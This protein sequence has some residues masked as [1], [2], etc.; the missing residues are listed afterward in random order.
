MNYGIVS[1]WRADGDHRKT[2][3]REDETAEDAEAAF[4]GRR[5][6]AGILVFLVLFWPRAARAAGFAT[7]HFGGEQGT[8][9]TSN[10]TA[11]YYNP[12]GIGFSEG[13]H[14]LLDG[15]LALRNLD[16]NHPRAPSDPVDPPGGEGANIGQAHSLNI[17]GAPAL[18]ATMKLGRFAFGAGFFVPFGGQ[19]SWDTNSRFSKSFFLAGAG[20]QRWHI[21][22]GQQ[23]YIYGTLGAAYRI[24]PLSV[25]AAGNLVL[26]SVSLLRAIVPPFGDP[27]TA[28]EGRAQL[29]VSAT[30]GGF[31]AGAELEA[32]PGRLWLA[33]SYQSQP[34]VGAQ[35]L[36]G[37]LKT[38]T[39]YSIPPAS[40]TQDV[41]FTQALP[42]V[43]RAGLRWRALEDVEL[44][45]FGDFT[46]W[47]VM[48]TQCLALPNSPCT[49]LPDGSAAP[50][51]NVL[52]NL[53]RN[54]NDTYHAHV[55]ASYW[56]KPEI[57]LFAGAG[58]ETAATPDTT[59]ETV[60][61]DADTIEGAVGGR[62]LVA[63]FIYV[64]VS[65]TH[66][67]SLNRDTTGL[68]NLADALQP[69]H[70]Q[71]AGGRYSQWVGLVDLNLEKSF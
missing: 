9:L 5:L 4:L 66:L 70:Q 59:L 3:R 2:R 30:N 29:D 57:E 21:I 23:A 67:Q 31:A 49:V 34:G 16:F 54:W 43:V 44:R 33:A 26:S 46:R 56:V 7:A 64:A 40:K 17:F 63:H 53:R 24:G 14:V 15:N 62:F 47:S 58:F 10:P 39:P 22:N 18:G 8:V 28:N 71:D 35:T 13:I 27:D 1:A 37:T 52:L 38:S 60:F 20:P 55:G 51:A 12:A 61:M 65:Y 6:R 36:T 19:E 32:V 45:V 41:A 11:L 68:N 42:D 69:T 48:R 25:G 50:G